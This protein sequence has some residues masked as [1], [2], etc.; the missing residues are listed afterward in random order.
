MEE[1]LADWHDGVL[2]NVL[3]QDQDLL[4]S[5]YAMLKQP[6]DKMCIRDRDRAVFGKP[7]PVYP[8]TDGRG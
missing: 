3:P 6:G 7:E 5:C 8:G 2:G 1:G 4:R